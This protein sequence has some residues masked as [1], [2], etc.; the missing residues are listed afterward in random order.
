MDCSVTKADQPLGVSPQVAD[1]PLIAPDIS[2]QIQ[3]IDNVDHKAGQV[4]IR[5][6]SLGYWVETG[7][8]YYV[9]AV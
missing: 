6:N 1:Q 7:E 2:I 3:L 4:I 9:K 5:V 8:D